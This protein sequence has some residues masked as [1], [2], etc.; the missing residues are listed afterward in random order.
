MGV[1]A[2]VGTRFFGKEG[3][4]KFIYTRRNMVVTDV[5]SSSGN[6]NPTD[7]QTYSDLTYEMVNQ[8]AW[9]KDR[10]LK[11]SEEILDTGSMFLGDK[12]VYVQAV[13]SALDEIVKN[14]DL[15]DASEET[16][17]KLHK[18][19][20]ESAMYYMIALDY[21]SLKSVYNG[22]EGDSSETGVAK[23][24]LFLEFLSSTGTTASAMFVMDCVR[25]G[26]CFEDSQ[27]SGRALLGIPYHVRRP[28]VQLVNEMKKLTSLS[29][30]EEAVTMALPLAIAHLAR[31][32]C[33]LADKSVADPGFIACV[34]SLLNPMSDEYF[35]KLM[36]ASSD[37]EK[38]E[39]LAVLQNIRWGK[40][41]DLLE[42]YLKSS[43][44]SDAVK[45]DA[46]TAAVYSTYIKR[47]TASYFLPIIINPLQGTETR[48]NALLCFIHGD[49]DITQL[50]TVVTTLYEEKNFEFKNYAYS[51]FE[52]FSDTLNPCFQKKKD[53]ISYYYRYMKQV[54]SHDINYGFGI[55]KFYVQEFESTRYEN[56]GSNFINIIGSTKSQL[57]L[58]LAVWVSSSNYEGYSASVLGIELRFEGLSRTVLKKIQSI[59]GRDWKLSNLKQLMDGMNIMLKQEE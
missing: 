29:N 27:S 31:R 59:N 30:Q 20:T 44:D 57:P 32:T 35:A 7:T 6:I 39:Y 49:F 4:S 10:N 22:L 46:V 9:N 5:K 26:K 23:M 54:R 17:N 58:K 12:S 34:D 42:D 28:N 51:L 1:E 8:Y 47:N 3:D 18:Y 41:S 45:A 19:G 16:V 40:I 14:F 50:S 15:H 21:D 36:S 24:K 2:G 33:E 53:L 37:D 25:Q 55:S 48:A 38:M 13:M 43:S 11:D 56:S 52:A